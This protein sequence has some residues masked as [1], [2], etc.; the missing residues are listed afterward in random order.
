MA[1][2]ADGIVL[3]DGAADE[4]RLLSAPV[5]AV[6]GPTAWLA[7]GLARL[8]WLTSGYGWLGLVVPV[9]V[10]VPVAAPG[11]FGGQMSFGTLMMVVGAFQQV[12]SALCWFVDNFAAIAD[13]RATLHRVP[14]F[15]EVLQEAEAIGAGAGRIE[16]RQGSG[17]AMEFGKLS[18]VLAGTC[19]SLDRDEV[20]IAPGERV[21]IVCA[22]EEG[23]NVLFRALAGIWPWGSGRLVLPPR[24]QVTFLPERRYMPPGPLRSALCS[25]AA[26][27][28]FAEDAAA[29]RAG[30]DA[31]LTETRPGARAR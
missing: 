26:P 17:G 31:V 24:E 14:A 20:R 22:T 27:E 29:S 4:R 16:L 19:A 28:K 11:Y 8:T 6:T 21:Q 10:P 13:W 3:E 25:L 30:L 2:N 9:P 12:Q 23:R 18:L 7:G 1:E 15:R 5:D